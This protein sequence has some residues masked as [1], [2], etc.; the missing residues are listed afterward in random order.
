MLPP[1]IDRQ[2]D[3]Q[4]RHAELLTRRNV[5][6][7]REDRG[8]VQ[9]GEA[10]LQSGFASVVEQRSQ[11]ID[12]TAGAGAT[13]GVRDECG[14]GGGQIRRVGPGQRVV[15]L[16]TEQ[17]GRPSFS[18]RVLPHVH[19]PYRLHSRL[20]PYVRFQEAAATGRKRRALCRV[21]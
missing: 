18:R 21:G 12:G 13:G 1:Y 2:S 15:N 8:T 4:V 9:T 3:V 10:Q 16:Y 11:Q 5:P 17:G 6:C 14:G 7:S 19:Y 20:R